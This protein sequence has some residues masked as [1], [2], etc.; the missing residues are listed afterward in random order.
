MATQT[1]P[2]STLISTL[3]EIVA[4]ECVGE[5]AYRL[6][7]MKRIGLSVPDAIVVT[8]AAFH[9]V[10]TSNQLDELIAAKVSALSVEDPYLTAEVSQEIEALVIS[11]ELPEKVASQFA[12]AVEPLLANGP[13]VVR[14]SACGEDSAEAAFAGQLDSFLEIGTLDA[15]LDALK[16]CWASYWSHRS[17]AYQLARHVQLDGMGVLVQ[18]Q[19]DASFAGVLF[20]R[21]LTDAPAPRMVAEYC[22]GLADQLVSGSI[23]PRSLTISWDG[24]ID[25]V[26]SGSASSD[27]ALSDD[28]LGHEHIP[29]LSSDVIE[30]LAQ[31]G[32]KLEEEF[33]DPQDIEWAVDRRDKL[34]IVQSRP[35]TALVDSNRPNS[36]VWSNANVNENFPDPVCPLLYSI[37]SVGYYH[38]FRNLGIVFGINADR[39]DEMEYP[40][41]NIIG[42]HGGR[43][44][45]NLTN[46]HAVLRAAPC[47]EFL[48]ESFNQFVGASPTARTDDSAKDQKQGR[49]SRWREL[50]RIGRRVLGCFRSMEHRIS[51]FESTVDLFAKDA[52]VAQLDQCNGTELLAL[53]RRFMEIRCQWTDASLADA[54]SMISYGLTQRFLATEFKEEEDQAIAN[55]LLTGL[56]D[57]VS[58]LPTE[59]LWSLSRNIRANNALQELL[60]NQPAS[61]VWDEIQTNPD[62][63]LVREGLD[64]FLERWGF[65]CSGE[66]MLTIPSYQEDPV[67]LLEMLRAFCMQT[68][69]S[70]GELLE[71]QQENRQ[72]ETERV[73]QALTKRP[74]TKWLPF[75]R[76]SFVARRL[77]RWTQRSVG[78]RERARL[79]QALLYS[80]YRRLALVVGQHF[81]EWGYLNSADDI[82]YLAHSEV[83]SLLAGSSMF[84]LET[85]SL[86]DLRRHAHE[87]LDAVSPP[88]RLELA[89]GESWHCHL[90]D[91]TNDYQ[92]NECGSGDQLATQM[93]GQGVCGGAIVGRAV[94]LTDPTQ[95]DEVD[96]G[97]ILVT[98]QTDPGWGPIL[99]LVKG[100]V[101]ER[102]GMLSH[103]AIIAREFGIPSVVDVRQATDRIVTGSTIRVDGDRGLVEILD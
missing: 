30:G 5:K 90:F 22:Q 48:A 82:F 17:L 91:D 71:R 96:Q 15:A 16:R 100:L 31:V 94:V 28:A 49:L 51:R 36:V 87:P 65:R 18:R 86:A 19:V 98:R 27:D 101:M 61:E 84:P 24:R 93:R 66:L 72:E 50:A 56:C 60:C 57:I 7:E 80:R 74:I 25:G 53:W 58:G 77:I 13:V 55:R 32:R 70:P 35:I 54:A 10:L 89:P 38:Y 44:Y 75:P 37:A 47:G 8:N 43:I 59:K 81:T 14:S 4:V 78:Y 67:A 20:T 62:Y 92:S 41:R 73:L 11:T 45:Y 76:K 12:A 34:H 3:S 29:S 95:F 99:F 103:G 97:D 63:R 88:D 79:K 42:V 2:S 69:E 40:L 85:P 1:L 26:D 9:A 83:E 52:H 64:E 46:I 102:G 21:D 6:A 39:I 23:I 33:G 68:G